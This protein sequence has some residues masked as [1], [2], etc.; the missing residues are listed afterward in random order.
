MCLIVIDQVAV[1]T[2][3]TANP[4]A[5]SRV[6]P[7]FGP[8]FGDEDVPSPCSLIA[9]IAAR[10]CRTVPMCV[11]PVQI[12]ASYQASTASESPR[13]IVFRLSM[14]NRNRQFLLSSTPVVH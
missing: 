2:K 10:A 1:Q 8:Y 4:L 3:N 14:M 6:F 12:V 11:K 9:S 5:I 13:S 7:G